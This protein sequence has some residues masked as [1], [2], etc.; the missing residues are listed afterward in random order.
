[1]TM[2]A[3]LKAGALQEQLQLHQ[4]CVGDERLGD[5]EDGPRQRRQEQA[6]QLPR[7]YVENIHGPASG[8]PSLRA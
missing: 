7:S 6:A 1:M 8:S 2:P 4:K 3:A 5:G